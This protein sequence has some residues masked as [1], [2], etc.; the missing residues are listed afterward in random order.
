ML[1]TILLSKILVLAIKLMAIFQKNYDMLLAIF[2][3]EGWLEISYP[4]TVSSLLY[5]SSFYVFA[6]HTKDSLSS[7]V[8]SP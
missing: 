5:C 7:S 3:P 2:N 6:K 1:L 8:S 4:S